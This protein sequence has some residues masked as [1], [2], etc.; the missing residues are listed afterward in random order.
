MKK[1]RIL[2]SALA[3]VFAVAA[4]FASHSANKPTLATAWFKVNQT[5]GALITPYVQLTTPI[6]CQTSPTNFC[7]KEYN[8]DGSGNPMVDQEPVTTRQGILIGQ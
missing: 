2:L 4:A 1:V 8:V 6:N 7:A 5:T 3:I